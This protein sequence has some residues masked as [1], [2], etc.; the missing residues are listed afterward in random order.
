M[1]E[2]KIFLKVDNHPEK[3][4]RVID[5]DGREVANVSDLK[6]HRGMLNDVAIEIKVWDNALAEKPDGT[7]GVFGKGRE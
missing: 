4:L 5:Q 2:S 6:V 3:G 7:Q 1:N